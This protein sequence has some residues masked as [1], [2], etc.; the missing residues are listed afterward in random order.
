MQKKLERSYSRKSEDI[1]EFFL[2]Q[3]QQ[4]SNESE[5]LT[6][7]ISDLENLN[8]KTLS[9]IIPV[10]SS[11]SINSFA[12]QSP[13]TPLGRSRMVNYDDMS[14]LNVPELVDRAKGRTLNQKKEF[15]R[16]RAIYLFKNNEINKEFDES[17]FEGENSYLNTYFTERKPLLSSK[18]LIMSGSKQFDGNFSINIRDKFYLS[19]AII[20]IFSAQTLANVLVDLSV[21]LL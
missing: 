9:I 14:S 21:F 13:K 5:I 2:N 16:N 19:C 1:T 12:N 6:K 11:S 18:T 7:S 3:L 15:I 17:L 8:E 10:A 20:Q 4:S